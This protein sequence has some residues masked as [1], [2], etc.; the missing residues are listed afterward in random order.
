MQFADERSRIVW[1]RQ[2]GKLVLAAALALGQTWPGLTDP[3][4]TEPA[5]AAVDADYVA[6]RKALDAKD[7]TAAIK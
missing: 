6:G 1:R 2:L 4:E 3:L 7:W 5:S